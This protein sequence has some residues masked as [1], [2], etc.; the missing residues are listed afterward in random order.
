MEAVLRPATTDFF[1]FVSKNNGTHQ[2]SK[3]LSEH[4]KAVQ[5]YQRRKKASEE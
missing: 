1:Y 3:N 5:E 4:N 2:F